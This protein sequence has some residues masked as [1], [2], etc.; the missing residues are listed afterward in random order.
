MSIFKAYD[1]R[2]VYPSEIDEKAARAIAAAF[3]DFLGARRI[4]LARDMRTHS[5]SLAEA[6]R[7]GALG[8]GADVV[9]AGLV[10]TPMSYFGVG[11]LELDG[12]LMVTASHNPG[13]YN[14]FK[15]CGRGAAPLSGDRGI[16]DIADRVARGVP[17]PGARRGTLTA[18]DLT[19]DYVDHVAAL[20]TRT[21]LR[22]AVDG[23]N[24]MGG[25]VALAILERLGCRVDAIYTEPDGRFP[26]HEANPLKE[27]NLRD[28]QALVRRT[29]ADLGIGFDGDADRA[30]VVDETGRTVPNDLLTA[31]LAADAL[32]RHPGTAVVYDLRSSWALR[33]EVEHAGGIPVRER[34][35]HSFLKATMRAR[36]AAFGGELSG[37]TYWQENYQADSAMIAMVR[38]LAVLHEA[39]R[40]L[41]A[42]VAP[43]RRYHG[44]GEVNFTVEDKDARIRE[45]A[46]AFADG[47]IDFL[48]GITVEYPD[49]WFNVRKSNTE[50][51]LRLV[52]ESRTAEGKARLLARVLA[53]LGEPERSA[54]A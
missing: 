5:P 31:L 51:L 28:L 18:R 7:E 3:V 27:E 40:P 21:P 42:L 2:G 11:R 50:P 4:L 37:H 29:G 26:H 15:L 41:S 54:H 49:G 1:I 14:G 10:T 9:D 35:G 24:G 16:P 45:I 22:V 6:A 46:R 32:K 39:G 43:L 30:I 12:G 53:V 23:G 44:T 33:E 20:G 52:L 48:D 13:Q 34:V 25:P 17:G 36:G 8:A 38:T 19:G 47:R